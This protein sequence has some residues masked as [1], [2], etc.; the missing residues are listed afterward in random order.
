[1][2]E[3][4]DL[5]GR[6]WAE[7]DCTAAARTALG[8]LVLK[9]RFLCDVLLRGAGRGFSIYRDHRYGQ[10]RG[11]SEAPLGQATGLEGADLDG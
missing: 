6:P 4:Q 5:L 11:A 2:I 7:M 10:P 3:Y 8:R 9:T 1:M